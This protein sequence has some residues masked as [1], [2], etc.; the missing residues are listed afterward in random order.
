MIALTNSEHIP[1]IQEES[2]SIDSEKSWLPWLIWGLGASL[3][4]IEYFARIFPSISSRYLTLDF[5]INAFQLGNLSAYFYY[6]YIIMQLPVGMLVDRFGSRR[7][8]TLSGVC[9]ALSSLMFAAAGHLWVAELSRV[10]LGFSASFAFVGA[11]RLAINWFPASKFGLLAGFTQALGMLGAAIGDTSMSIAVEHIGWRSTLVVIAIVF[12][13]LGLL[14]WFIVRDFPR[15]HTKTLSPQTWSGGRHMLKGLVTV[16][17]NRASWMNAFYV[18]FIYGPTAAFA[19]LWGVPFIHQQYGL[20]TPEAA[21]G[22]GLIFIGWAVGGPVFGWL[23]DL[24]QRRRPVMFISALSGLL[25]M[26]GIIYIPHMPIPI[27]FLLLFLYGF[28]NTG[29]VIS[30]ALSS[31]INPRSVA[32][33]SLAFA[34]MASVLIGAVFQPIIGALLDWHWGKTKIY[35]HGLPFYSIADY[36]VAL[37]VLPVF[38]FLGLIMANFVKETYCMPLE[39][40]EKMTRE[41]LIAF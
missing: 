26:L 41:E 7:L 39:Q 20:T 29:V 2:Q 19:E 11:L 6:P 17:G 4:F 37:M 33:T 22:I 32:G 9:C 10:L 25:I 14:V 31:E 18:G 3:F 21:T 1:Y 34:N 30:Y 36:Q 24:I 40:R 15:H 5:H 13:I 12:F 23:S 38:L 8:L 27:L 28:T 35:V 16:L